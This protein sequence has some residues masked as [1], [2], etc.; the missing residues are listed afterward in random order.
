M[1]DSTLFDHKLPPSAADS[2]ADALVSV[3]MHDIVYMDFRGPNVLL[4]DLRAD[5]AGGAAAT[6][7]SAASALTDA[8]PAVF[9]DYDDAKHVP[10]RSC[11]TQ[12]RGT[13]TPSTSWR[14]Q[15]R[16]RIRPSFL[17]PTLQRLSRPS[18][19]SASAWNVLRAML[20]PLRLRLVLPL[21]LRMSLLPAFHCSA[22]GRAVDRRRHVSRRIR[23]GIGCGLGSC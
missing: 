7:A 5:A 22:C 21:R 15:R 4:R 6:A 3:T 13:P 23:V 17:L 14:L 1:T 2:I 9:I 12:Q 8:P 10:G 19:G 18:S 11:L 16:R 20:L